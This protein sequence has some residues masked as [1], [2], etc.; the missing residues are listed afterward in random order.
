MVAF[1]RNFAVFHAERVVRL[2]PPH[3]CKAEALTKFNALDCRN[4]EQQVAQH[5]LDTIKERRAQPCRKPRHHALQHAANGILLIPCRQ[6]RFFHLLI[7]PR[8]QHGQVHPLEERIVRRR[9]CRQE[10]RVPHVA[11]LLD[12]AGDFYALMHQILAAQ[13]ACQHNPRRQPTGEAAAAAPI[14][15]AEVAH[16]PGVIRMTR[17]HQIHTVAIVLRALIRVAD[18]GANRLTRRPPVQHT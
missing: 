6:H 8:R 3:G 5:T 13:C 15:K 1:R 4:R 10:R 18:D 2:T 9:I 11:Q 17:T 14:L 12:V 16:M 7:Q